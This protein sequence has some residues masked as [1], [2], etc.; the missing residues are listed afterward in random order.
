M[1][2]SVDAVAEAL[3][4]EGYVTGREV[5]TQVFLAARLGKPLLVE[6]PPGSGRSTL[7][8][9]IA[10]A[11]G[12][13]ISSVVCHPG[14]EAADATHS[15]D[16]SGQLLHVQ[17]ALAAGSSTEKA[18][19]EAFSEPYLISGPVLRAFNEEGPVSPVLL[20]LDIDR[21][22]VPF[23]L[24][25]AA[26]LETLACDIPGI[27]KISAK[28]PPLAILTA[29]D[30]SGVSEHLTRRALALSLAYPSFESEVE[31][32]VSH[33]PGIARPLAGQVANFLGRLRR[34]P[35][36]SRP[37][38]GES[39]DWALALVALRASSLSPEI[40]DQTVG[41]ILKDPR[42]IA[43]FRARKFVSMLAGGMD[44]SG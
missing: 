9:L 15:W 8:R 18:R 1:F 16:S 43:E 44:R 38:L 21:A 12:A 14:I 19:A 31:I 33:V 27:G 23:Q 25:L 37:G 41:C 17:E 13:P 39:L 42:D 36:N 7:G 11:S 20:V 22:P 24:W 28:R 40:V 30:A 32:L 3:R 26:T 4:A 29:T 6:G 5:A 2:E 34:Q 10:A 35:L